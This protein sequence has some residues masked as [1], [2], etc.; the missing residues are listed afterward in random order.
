MTEMAP[1]GTVAHLP[2]RRGGRRR[3]RKFAYRAKQGRPA[4][5]VEIRARNEDGLVPWDGADDGRARSAR[6]VDR[7]RLLRPRRLRP[8][9][10][11]TMAGSRPATSSPSIADATIQMQDRI[12]GSDQVGRRVDQLGRARVRADGPSG[13]GRSGGHPGDAIRKWSRA[14][15]GRGRAQAGRERVAG[16]PARISGAAV[17]RSSGC[18]TRSS[19]STPFRARRPE[20]SRRASCASGS[21]TISW[22]NESDPEV[23]AGRR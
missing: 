6:P 13:G 2:R 18:P 15:A 8:I 22:P 10:S 7:E 5:F 20:S 14:P 1:L 9:G 3:R 23:R 4:P 21:R 16:R 12:E 11:P 17:S 19:S